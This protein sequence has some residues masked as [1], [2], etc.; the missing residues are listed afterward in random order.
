M[1]DIREINIVRTYDASQEQVF[2]AWTEAEQFQQWWRVEGF[3]TPV[4]SVTIDARA[5][6][7]WTATM[8]ADDGSKTVPFSGA[9]AVVE[10][11]SKLRYSLVDANDPRSGE[12]QDEFVSVAFKGIGSKTELTFTQVG[13]LSEEDLPRA[14]EGWN[15]FLDRLGEHLER[16]T[17]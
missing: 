15:G 5:G 14:T 8:I 9:Y 10:A 3:T 16:V 2:A 6:G 7:T 12:E 13:H 17:N 1:S 4:E 11:P